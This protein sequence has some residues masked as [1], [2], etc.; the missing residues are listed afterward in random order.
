MLKIENVNKNYPDF[1]LHNVSFELPD[2]FIM[3][4]IGNNGAGKSTTLKS[5]LNIVKPDSGKIEVFGK[6]IIDHQLEIKQQVGFTLGSFEYYQKYKL[7]RIVASYKKFY[8]CW[9]E[10]EYRR[11]L[12]KFGL[13]EN[14]R[15]SELSQGMKVKFSLA[16]A[17]SHNAKLFILDE[18]TSGLDPLSRDEVLEL[19]QE[20]VENGDK[21]ILFS[22]HIT[23]DL[24]KCADYIVFIKDGR[25]IANN[26]KDDLI[27][28]HAL[29]CGKKE[30][31][32]DSLKK[33]VV[34]YKLNAHGFRA[35]IRR[36][37]LNSIDDVE[38][39]TPTLEDISIYYNKEHN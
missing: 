9:D 11:L 6:N 17:M 4:F 7:K 39:E 27:D 31:L 34:S 30:S 14:K 10:S 26:E 22:T 8:D 18:P 3:G 16:L 38:I 35:L 25:I 21:S 12:V 36:C 33:R 13:N 15:I 28:S 37:D 1:K 2:G 19:F 20:I 32:N 5:I 29:I 24:D 23:S